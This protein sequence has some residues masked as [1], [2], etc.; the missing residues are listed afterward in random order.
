MCVC[1]FSCARCARACACCC[2]SVCALRV[3]VCVFARALRARIFHDDDVLV[4]LYVCVLSVSRARVYMYLCVRARA[5]ALLR[6]CA[7]AS[8]C[9]C[10]RVQTRAL[11]PTSVR[12]LVCVSVQ[13]H[14]CIYVVCL[15]FFISR[16]RF[17]RVHVC[18]Y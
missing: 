13:E 3:R 8:L 9:V 5:C 16:A 17:A 11:A 4:S 14:M 15:R 6:V 1:L 18:E 12:V 10:I 7:R 2:I